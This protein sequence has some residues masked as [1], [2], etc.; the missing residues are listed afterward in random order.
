MHVYV[1]VC[2]RAYECMYVLSDVYMWLNISRATIQ[3]VVRCIIYINALCVCFCKVRTVRSRFIPE[4]SLSVCFSASASVAVSDVVFVCLCLSIS[5]CLSLSVCL[6][7]CLSVSLT[8]S[9]C[10][11]ARLS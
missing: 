7:L 9:L 1:Q 3:D 8:L 4:S 10:I 5:V 6:C 2:M 11:S